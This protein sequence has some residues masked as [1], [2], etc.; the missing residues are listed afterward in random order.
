MKHGFLLG[1]PALPVRRF[2]AKN[3]NR[4]RLLATKSGE[5]CGLITESPER[6]Q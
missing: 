4:L 1:P 3:K 2:A 5:K 6:A